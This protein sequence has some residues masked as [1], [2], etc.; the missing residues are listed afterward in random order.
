MRDEYSDYS[1]FI[2]DMI[3]SNKYKKHGLKSHFPD[4]LTNSPK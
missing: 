3:L 2:D 4:F 1:N